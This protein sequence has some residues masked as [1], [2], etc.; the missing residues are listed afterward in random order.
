MSGEKC[1]ELPTRY[2]I[3]P[4]PCKRDGFHKELEQVLDAGARLVQLRAKAMDEPGYRK[5]AS[6]SLKLCR[7][8]GARLL[9]NA[10]VEWVEQVGADGVHLTCTRLMALRERPLAH[11]L[12]VGASCHSAAQLAQA[13]SVG[14][15]F[16]VL[17]PV[18]VTSSHPE[19]QPMGWSRFKQLVESVPIPVF[20]LG[21]MKLGHEAMAIGHG[22]HGIAAI[23]GLWVDQF[24]YVS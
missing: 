16:A 9:L 7:E 12:W 13:V 15:D 14:V 1:V 21:G 18:L 8:Y 11:R 17:G 4:D 5:L 24:R 3:T 22:G 10:P 19:A 23:R 2:V 20:A 6:D